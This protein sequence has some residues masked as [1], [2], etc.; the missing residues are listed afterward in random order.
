MK[1][2]L[3]KAEKPM[4]HETATHS[5]GAN[6]T[7]E[8]QKADAPKVGAISVARFT[9]NGQVKSLNRPVTG[10]EL[11][12]IAGSPEKLTVDGKAIANDAEPI[13]LADD[14]ELKASY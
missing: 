12:R 5:S 13:D 8:H 1:V 10:A 4:P 9:V 2:P 14:A 11:Y 7:S 6:R 3:K